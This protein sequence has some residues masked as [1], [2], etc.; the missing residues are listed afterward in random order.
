MSS[1]GSERLLLLPARN[2][3]RPESV[4]AAKADGLVVACDF[5]VEGAE[6]GTE[7][8]GGYQL[9]RILN[10]DHHA[11][12]QRMARIVSSTNL[13]IAQVHAAHADP[14]AAIVLNHTDCDSILSGAIMAGLLPPDPRFG[15]AAI[16]AD[17]T[18]EEDPIADLLQ[19]LQP[20][21]DPGL[22]LR[23]LAALRNGDPLEP[24]AAERL[25]SRL[26]DRGRAERYVS[27]ERFHSAGCVRWAV[28]ERAIDGT[29]L[30]SLLPDACVILL[31]TPMKGDAGRW[32]AKLRLGLAAPE[33]FSLHDLGIGDFDPGFGCRWNAGSN[34]RAGGTPLPAADY[35]VRLADAIDR[36]LRMM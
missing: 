6:A 31:A 4:L 7:V 1:P 13:A 19:A 29:F 34:K 17:H 2:P 27:E 20:C 28:L 30:P 21:R 16:A 15:E 25:A 36:R 18:G 11:P 32:E 12:T 5:H 35:A 22:S 26:Q 24:V 10:V 3:M 33:G 23:S 9:G 14:D 8:P